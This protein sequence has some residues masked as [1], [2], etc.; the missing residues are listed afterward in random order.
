M[1]I[2]TTVFGNRR[3]VGLRRVALMLRKAILRVFSGKRVHVFVA[4]RFGQNAGR[5][6]GRKP[7]VAFYKTLVHNPEI[8]FKSIAVDQKQFRPYFKLIDCPV[9]GQ[10]GRL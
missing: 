8:R 7:A 2:A 3:A 9:H 5:G 1:L 6:N 10:K 4:V